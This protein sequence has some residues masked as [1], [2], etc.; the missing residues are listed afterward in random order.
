MNGKDTC[1]FKIHLNKVLK[2]KFGCINELNFRYLENLLILISS[3]IAVVGVDITG[4]YASAIY[5]CHF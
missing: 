1:L 2:L 3:F 4:I 5:S